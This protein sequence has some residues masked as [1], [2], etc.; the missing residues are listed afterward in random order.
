MP[1]AP[2]GTDVVIRPAR[3]LFATALAGLVVAC[4]APGPD[5]AVAPGGA[6]R[7]A[8]LLAGRYFGV[9]VGARPGGDGNGQSIR[10]EARRVAVADGGAAVLL[11]QRDAEDRIRRFRMTMRA[12]SVATRLTG[13][14]EPLSADGAVLGRCALE[15]TL[16]REGFVARTDAADCRF[17]DSRSATALV[18]EIA[19][20]GRRLVIGDRVVDPDTGAARGD[21][22]IIEFLRVRTFSGWAG[23]AADGGPWRRAEPFD[24]DADATPFRP[25]DASGMPLGIELELAPYRLSAQQ[26]TVLRLRIFDLDDGRLLGQAWADPAA[27][28]IGLAARGLQVGLRAER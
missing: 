11:E 15:Y 20:D 4:A 27:T 9:G 8:G 13:S 28:R 26:A 5:P 14:F 18:K 12:T 6:D 19:H 24:I 23:V 7:V 16:R 17:G 3:A 1:A 25:D 10:L 2:A 22:R 21:D